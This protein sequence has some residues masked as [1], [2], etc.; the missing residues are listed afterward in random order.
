MTLIVWPLHVAV[1]AA[2]VIVIPRSRSW[3]IQSIAV[4]PSSTPPILR[5]RPARYRTRSV[6][7]VLP[8]S[9]W[10]MKPMFRVRSSRGPPRA[11]AA[12]G[13]LR[14][15]V[16][17][18][19]GRCLGA[20]GDAGLLPAVV[21]EDPVGLGHAVE[22]LLALDRGALAAGGLEELLGEPLRDRAAGL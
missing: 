21:G 2:E 4:V 6:T 12:F 11:G 14:A 7:V 19:V 9:M 5:M 22:V 18:I 17:V 16:V 1:V 15:V 8:A 3:A 13:L 10:A 20:V